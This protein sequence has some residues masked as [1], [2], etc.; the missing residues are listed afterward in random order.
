MKAFPGKLLAVVLGLLVLTYYRGFVSFSAFAEAHQP[1]AYADDIETYLK[2][3]MET[4]K[5]P[6]LAIAIVRNGEAEYV[7]GF[8]IANGRGR[9]LQPTRRSCSTR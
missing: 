4:Y 5:I 7:K 3:Q 9:W 2:T 6:G 1:G 8:G